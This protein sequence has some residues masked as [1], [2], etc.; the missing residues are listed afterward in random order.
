M[1]LNLKHV[2]Q[3][4]K[5]SNIRDRDE[6]TFH[7]FHF[8]ATT[9]GS[10]STCRRASCSTPPTVHDFLKAKE[11]WAVYPR[12]RTRTGPLYRASWIACALYCAEC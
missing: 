2:E 12:N 5:N 3:L 10:F 1:P 6:G 8:A 9:E 7:T 4:F 11:S